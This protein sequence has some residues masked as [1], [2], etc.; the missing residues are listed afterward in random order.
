[1]AQRTTSLKRPS[2][3]ARPGPSRRSQRSPR[4]VGIRIV[5]ADH[6]A[7]DRRGIVGLLQSTGGFEVVGESASV[8]ETVRQCR[9]HVPDVLLLTLNLPGQAHEAAIPAIRAELRELRI[10]AL[11]ERGSEICL[12]LNPP[13]RTRANGTSHASFHAGIDCLQLAAAQGANATL[14]RSADPEELFETL[15]AV[16]RGEDSHAAP[17]APAMPAIAVRDIVQAQGGHPLLSPREIQVAALIAEGQANKEI[18]AAL[19]ISGPTVKKHVG[20]ILEKL[21]LADRLQAGLL[22]A[23]NPLLLKR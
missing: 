14:R 10:L 3:S 11:S 2:R 7:I 6:Q 20:H 1:M 4:P 21:G 19:G 8:E 18:S 23:R 16:A 12:V 5:V 9:A 15:R 22:L 17:R 13:S